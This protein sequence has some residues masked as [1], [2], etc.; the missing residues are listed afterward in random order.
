MS[1]FGMLVGIRGR[2]YI[3]K[4]ESTSSH[5]I[6]GKV[7]VAS[8]LYRK[9]GT[10]AC[11]LIPSVAFFVRRLARTL[12]RRPGFACGADVLGRTGDKA[13]GPRPSRVSGLLRKPPVP[14]G[15]P[16][17]VRRQADA[18]RAREAPL[19]LG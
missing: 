11:H 1:N 3:P 9:L 15:R 8:T 16:V 2:G 10:A 18:N 5:R 13:R 7:I 4:I 14:N 12:R 19:R 17:D 6:L